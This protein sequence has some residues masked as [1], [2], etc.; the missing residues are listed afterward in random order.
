MS[1]RR[2]EWYLMGP[3]VKREVAC[4]ICTPG[5]DGYRVIGHNWCAR[6]QCFCPRAEGEGYEK[7]SSVCGQL[8]H[9]ET[10]AAMMM[11]M[12]KDADWAGSAAYLYGHTHFCDS[13][14]AALRERGVTRFVVVSD[15]SLERSEE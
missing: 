4:V 3:C 2:R 8:G 13:C 11:D 12:V 5:H 7:C 14:K 1:N 10:V 9:A 15:A 6:P